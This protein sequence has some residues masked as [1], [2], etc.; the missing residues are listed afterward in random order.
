M[1]QINSYCQWWPLVLSSICTG[2]FQFSSLKYLVWWTGFFSQFET[3]WIFFPVQTWFFPSFWARVKYFDG[4]CLTIYSLSTNHSIVLV[5]ITY[6]FLV[7]WIHYIHRCESKRWKP[8]KIK[9][10]EFPIFYPLASIQWP[11]NDLKN[12]HLF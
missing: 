1:F 2:F 6:Q 9:S 7:W 11:K 12:D 8:G 3:N 4:P 5:Y 10:S